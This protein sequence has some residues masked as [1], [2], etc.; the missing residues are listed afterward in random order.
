M[1]DVPNEAFLKALTVCGTPGVCPLFIRMSKGGRGLPS[2]RAVVGPH[3]PLLSYRKIAPVVDISSVRYILG[4]PWA[5][6]TPLS[7]PGVH[8]STIILDH[9]YGERL[10]TCS[11]QAVGTGYES[12][13]KS[14]FFRGQL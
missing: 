12:K 13:E 4:S 10:T 11:R 14:T 2:A 5:G 6:A 3:V 1:C 7:P 8:L 9:L